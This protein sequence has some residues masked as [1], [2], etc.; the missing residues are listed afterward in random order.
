MNSLNRNKIS[1]FVIGPLIKKEHLPVQME[2]FS[3]KFFVGCPLYPKRPTLK[4]K[5]LLLSINSQ[6]GC[7]HL[8]VNK[9]KDLE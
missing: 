3:Y 1:G 5:H 6:D 4:P 9:T 7:S 2:D 8:P